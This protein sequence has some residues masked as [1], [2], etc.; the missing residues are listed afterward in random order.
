MENNINK[1]Q[2]PFRRLLNE[3]AREQADA[4]RGKRPRGFWT[5]IVYGYIVANPG[6]TRANAARS[7]EPLRSS[8]LGRKI[9]KNLI[10]KNW[11][12]L[13]ARQLFVV[14]QSKANDMNMWDDLP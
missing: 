2:R 4:K 6:C 8:Q 14:D 11:I 12:K 13:E 10:D 1:P 5:R 3:I 9:I 7:I